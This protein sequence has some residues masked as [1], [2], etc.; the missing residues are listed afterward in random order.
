MDIFLC[1]YT[2]KCYKSGNIQK[3][4]ILGDYI[5]RIDE[6]NCVLRKT[7]LDY[8]CSF[9]LIKKAGGKELENFLNFKR[10]FLTE[11]TAWECVHYFFYINRF[12]S[13]QKK[14]QI[15]Q[16]D[17]F[18]RSEGFLLKYVVSIYYFRSKH[19]LKKFSVSSTLKVYLRQKT[20]FGHMMT[21]DL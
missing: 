5:Y 6:H 19:F 20:I 1:I 17:E 2:C 16:H 12:T 7:K 13:I 11:N 14:T 15:F 21:L 3:V 4:C 18:R 10:S 9:H 8:S